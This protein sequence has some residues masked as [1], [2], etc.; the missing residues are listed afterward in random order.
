M[1]ETNRSTQRR[2]PYPP[3][4]L[5][6]PA[7]VL[8]ALTVA[9]AAWAQASVASAQPAQQS[10]PPE[11]Q[12]LWQRSL[13]DALALSQAE[14]RPILIAVN[15]DGESA[16]ERIVHERY[17]DPAFVASTR[18]F[19]CLV[20]S[21]F[22]HTPRDYDEQG[23]RIPCPRLGEITCGEHIALEPI[24]YEKYLQGDRI[25]P[26]HALILTDGTKSFDLTLLFDLHDLDKKLVESQPLAPPASVRAPSAITAGAI[27]AEKSPERRMEMW[28]A[29]A[30]L[31][32]QHGRLALET[33]LL[34][35]TSE[36][37]LREAL[38]GIE[39]GGDAGSI[40]ALRVLIP[41]STALS[42]AF[43]DEMSQAAKQL[44]IEAPM[45]LAVREKI[46]G[47]GPF[48]GSPDIGADSKLLRVLAALDGA[49]PS[50]RSLLIAHYLIGPTYSSE[51]MKA[52]ALSGSWKGNGLDTAAGDQAEPLNLLQL[53]QFAEAAS[54]RFQPIAKPSEDMPS[55]E[56]LEGEL[57]ELDRA[58]KD[59]P[60]HAVL[61]ERYGIASLNLARRRIEAGGPGAQFLLDDADHWLNQA[62]QRHPSWRVYVELARTAYFRGKFADE[63]RY[64]EAAL[65]QVYDKLA[66][67]PHAQ[68]LLR[69][70]KQSDPDRPD[71]RLIETAAKLLE[72]R[73]AVEALR[74]IGDGNAR[75]LGER[76]G[77]DFAQEEQGIQRGAE[78][79]ALVASSLSS[80]ETDWTSFGSFFGALG[81]NREEL[82]CL[83]QGALRLPEST[84]LRAS[85]NGA[86]WSSGRIDLAP[87]KAEWILSK[88]P[89]SAASMWFA[90]Y[91]HILGAEDW[92]RREDA[93]HAIEAYHRAEQRLRESA[94]K[95]PE[96]E[97]SV[98]HYLA[99]A[100][101]GRGF[102]QSIADR[103]DKAA[104]CLAQA[105]V[106][107]PEVVKARDGLDREAIDLVDASLEWR[108]SGNSPVDAMALLD[109]LEKADPKN[110][111]WAR[112]IS[113]SELREA[114]RADGREDT[115][116]GDRFL[117]VSIA[118]AR[119]G[120]AIAD[121]RENRRPL[122]QSL[123]VAGERRLDHGEIDAARKF[124]GEAAPLMGLSAPAA[125]AGEAALKELATA[126]RKQLGAPRPV[127]RPGR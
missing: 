33:A 31:R 93:E 21:V 74:W 44:K 35:E 110:A 84:A 12:I 60:D 115:A 10:V 111:S 91:A 120:V 98:K 113:D 4:G 75:L 18:P 88:H 40:G 65:N 117:D 6:R 105:V 8:A 123:T 106:L 102:A 61:M 23:R 25:A 108:E 53:L 11:R 95:K 71:T 57:E 70:L 100:A 2:I 116:E 107:E 56:A 20:A 38:Q 69:E 48:P 55:A 62:A 64:G 81:M 89:D 51:A 28:L 78:A 17:R 5:I 63:V 27:D 30:R 112:S 82:A 67:G 59:K 73:E 14:H 127:V 13:A 29:L 90:G 121:D 104:E 83:Q 66:I 19:V 36:S 16:C 114:L 9:L 85:L 54:L 32:D 97:A 37:A 80:D 122:A 72:D 77:G 52:L 68:E 126:L 92:R 101:L 109:A 124:L 87:A 7:R 45:A 94:E 103:R 76:S 79:L 3:R 119:R 41:K 39:G 43:I 46:C 26:R 49:S 1:H 50:T 42:E 58:M 47:L 118:A 96:F 15:M 99:I 24:L 86:L 125:D 22:R 34:A